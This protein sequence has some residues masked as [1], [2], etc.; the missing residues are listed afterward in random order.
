[1]HRLGENISTVYVNMVQYENGIV[2]DGNYQHAEIIMPAVNS[3]IDMYYYFA[4]DGENF[5]ESDRLTVHLKVKD[6][7]SVHVDDLKTVNIIYQD[8]NGKE[9]ADRNSIK[10]YAGFTYSVEKKDVPGYKLINEDDVRDGNMNFE[11]PTK[12][13]V[14][15]YRKIVNTYISSGDISTDTKPNGSILSDI[16]RDIEKMIENLDIKNISWDDQIRNFKSSSI[17][18]IGELID[19]LGK[20]SEKLN[21]TQVSKIYGK[22]RTDTSIALSRALYKSSSDV[23]IVSSKSNQD[24]INASTLSQ[25]LGAPVFIVNNDD[26]MRR[27]ESEIER[28]GAK[29]VT[30]V[31]GENSISKSKEG[32]LSKEGRNISRFSGENRYETANKILQASLKSSGSDTVILINENKVSDYMSAQV[33][34]QKTGFPIAISK[35]SSID[36]SIFDTIK[37]SGVQNMIVVGGENSISNTAISDLGINTYR[38]SGK[39]RYDTSAKV[40]KSFGVN[41][42]NVVLTNGSYFPDAILA[43]QFSYRTAT[44]IAISSSISSGSEKLDAKNIFVIGK[45]S[46]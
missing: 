11:G 2:G 17:N 38:I 18:S 6:S 14:L 21:G 5:I 28:L 4:P 41:S 33:I 25:S 36:K 29:N 31:G 16:N 19:G 8:E 34:S 27:V 10:G 46:I 13:V 44:P 43:A 39:D 45:K 3:P 32:I 24:G 30:I 12:N 7:N 26:D 35:K 1:M 20:P 37:K 9:I 22:N 42:E 40:L 15:R 23:I